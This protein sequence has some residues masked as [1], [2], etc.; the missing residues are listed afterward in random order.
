MS[1]AEQEPPKLDALPNGNGPHKSYRELL[2]YFRKDIRKRLYAHLHRLPLSYH[3]QRKA[4]DTLVRLSS[5]IV[6]LRDVLV[7]AIVS[8]GTGLLTILMMITVMA[9]IDPVLTGVA[10]LV[11]PIVFALSYFYGRRIRANSQKQRKREGQVAAAMHE[12]LSSM[13]IVQLHG[14]SER[15]QE[16]FHEINRRSLK[17]GV[18]STRLEAQM[19]RSVE[20]T[21]AAGVALLLS[22]GTIRTLHGALTPGELIVFVM[23]LRAAY[24]PLQR[25][26]KTVQRAAKA[27]AAAERVVEVLEVEPALRDADDAREAPPLKGKIAFQ[28]V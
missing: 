26:S 6:L 20:I 18:A 5:D 9:L 23:Y 15:E 11:M 13:A 19:F 17:Q 1:L 27:Q 8:L 2:H 4:G 7:D 24:R 22:F 12:A 28:G 14:A 3:Q 25:A 16:R 21:L 10:L